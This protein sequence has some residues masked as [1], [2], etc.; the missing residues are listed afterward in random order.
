M[1]TSNLV[2]VCV[3]GKPIKVSTA[4][5]DDAEAGITVLLS[6]LG[7]AGE[8]AARFA[9]SAATI[10]NS[11]EYE[12]CSECLGDLD[13]HEIGPGPFGE[14]HAWCLK[15]VCCGHVSASAGEAVDHERG[16]WKV[17]READAAYLGCFV[18][19]PAASA[20]IGTLPGHADGLYG[21]DAPSA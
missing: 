21:I 20:F 18:S 5:P 3:Y 13:A 15:C 19:E 1:T 2:T 8:D 6:G 4:D 11:F 10:V 16:Q 14:A 17:I 9:Q 7:I 12:L